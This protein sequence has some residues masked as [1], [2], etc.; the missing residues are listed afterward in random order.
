MSKPKI[1]VS[2]SRADTDYVSRLVEDLR[3]NGFDVWFDANIR[4]GNEWDNT[5]E[6][7]IKKA[8]VMVLILSA[9]SVDSENV[10]DEM[11]YAM[12]L[13]KFVNPIKIEECD[14][15]MRLARRQYVDFNTMGYADGLDRLIVD[16]N[17][18]VKGKEH[19]KSNPAVGE[20]KNDPVKKETKAPVAA[21][22]KLASESKVSPAGTTSSSTASK[23]LP[24]KKN[25]L[26][27]YI[28]GGIA[29]VL[30]GVFV[31]PKLL[32]DNDKNAFDIAMSQDTKGA[33][34]TYLSTYAQGKFAL[35]AR[36]SVDSKV[37]KVRAAESIRLIQEEET[38]WVKTTQEGDKIAYEI[39]IRDYREGRY[40]NQA[41]DSIQKLEKDAANIA[42]DNANW[43][44]VKNKNNVSDYLAYYMDPNVIGL[45]KDDAKAKVAEIGN[46][47]YLYYGR[48]NGDKASNDRMFNVIC[49]GGSE[50]M[51]D[52][53]PATGDIL[54]TLE[55]RY[56]YRDI[57]TR[58][59]TGKLVEKGKRAFVTGVKASAD[60]SI[61]VKVLY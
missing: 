50:V 23:T 56:T 11:S 60:N 39:Y 61:I 5:L 46:T 47:G 16:I 38:Q 12:N 45:H 7:E 21:P 49:C 34:E 52:K 42:K 25:S 58:T 36:D 22:S 9:T 55:S 2:Y 15:P 26:L 19:S 1:F 37:N 10:K 33:Y 57:K 51:D 20:V 30:V 13:D 32:P 48:R 54:M 28:A 3:T 40:V 44:I 24:Q 41:L 53:I 29:L 17:Y 18:Q 59:K 35:Q 6:A 14:I 4:T 8:D 27:Y 43:A 31:V